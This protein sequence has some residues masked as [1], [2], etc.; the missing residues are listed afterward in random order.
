MDLVPR[1][2]LRTREEGLMRANQKIAELQMELSIINMRYIVLRNEF[3]EIIDEIN[4]CKIHII[5]E[6]E[7]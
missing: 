3:D 5:Q 2:L 6:E 1:E 4:E 7:K